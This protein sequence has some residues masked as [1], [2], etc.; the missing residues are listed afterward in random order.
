MI[1]EGITHRFPVS[2][3]AS[4]AVSERSPRN[5]R[6]ATSNHRQHRE[7]S[8]DEFHRRH[9]SGP[10]VASGISAQDV[11]ERGSQLEGP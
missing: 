7:P 1:R 9:E 3:G 5:W 8:I 11:T 4:C 6:F 2:A 10:L